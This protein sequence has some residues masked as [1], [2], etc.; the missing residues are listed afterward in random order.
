VALLC[1]IGCCQWLIYNLVVYEFMIA[2]DT[3]FYRDADRK[4]ADGQVVLLTI[5]LMIF[6]QVK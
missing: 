6:I 4:Y 3:I 1:L 5:G 2:V